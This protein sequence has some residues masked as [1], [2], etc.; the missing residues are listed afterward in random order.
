VV[1]WQIGGQVLNGGT[2]SAFLGCNDGNANTASDWW[3]TYIST[4]K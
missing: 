3:L 2:Y 4:V 1:W